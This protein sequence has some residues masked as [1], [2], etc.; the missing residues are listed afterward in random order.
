M[1]V[2]QLMRLSLNLILIK[3]VIKVETEA[4]INEPFEEYVNL[5]DVKPVDNTWSEVEKVINVEVI[6]LK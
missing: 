6:G 3:D 5:I 4:K 2:S 1:K